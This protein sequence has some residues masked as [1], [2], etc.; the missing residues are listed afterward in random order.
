MDC[1]TNWQGLGGCSCNGTAGWKSA[2][3]RAKTQAET[4]T[5]ALIDYDESHRSDYEANFEK[6]ATEIDKLDNEMKAIFSGHKGL[7]FLVFHPSWGYFAESYG[8]HQVALE[9]EGKDPKPAQL[10]ELIEH[11]REENIKVLF[12]QPQ[13]SRKSADLIAR[14]IGGQVAFADPLAE[15]WINNL[16]SVAMKFKAALK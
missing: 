10:A 3:L 11:A 16:R 14:E 8:L 2:H 5:E 1:A 13:F 7:Q 6:L 4:I 9:I 12:V 15:D